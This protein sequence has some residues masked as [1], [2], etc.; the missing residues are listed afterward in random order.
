[1]QNLIIEELKKIHPKH[2]LSE[3]DVSAHTKSAQK[4]TKEWQDAVCSDLI[5]R[6]V[7]V[8][9]SSNEKI[10][11]V[12]LSSLVAYEL[13]VSGKNTH[14]EFYKDLIKVLT[15]NEYSDTN[16]K[17]KKLVFISESSGIT[18]LL[19][20]LDKKF[21]VMLKNTHDLSIELVGI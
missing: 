20:R 12:D 14:H 10:D 2:R 11:I 19:G 21:V 9:Q 18:S 4:I 16:K 1:M 6:E 5:H 15:Y 3:G 13:K 8:S 17:L 7:K